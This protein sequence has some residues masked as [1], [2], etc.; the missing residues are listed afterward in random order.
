LKGWRFDID[1][2]ARA[3][4][5][6]LRGYPG[7][8]V[9]FAKIGERACRDP[10]LRGTFAAEDDQLTVPVGVDARKDRD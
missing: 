5:E 9:I 7:D 2:L 3:E 10:K 8:A 6:R 4:A 1:A